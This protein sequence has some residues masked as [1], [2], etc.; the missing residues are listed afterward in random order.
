[1]RA[2]VLAGFAVAVVT[3]LGVTISQHLTTTSAETST[4]QMR[5]TVT[6]GGTCVGQTCTV[7]PGQPFTLT[8]VAD[9]ANADMHIGFQTQVN[10]NSLAANGGSYNPTAQANAEIVIATCGYPG[11]PI[12]NSP[13]P[14][15]VGHGATAGFPGGFT[16]CSSAGNLISLSMTCSAS[17]S[18]NEFFL[19]PYSA[20]NTTGSMW[21][22]PVDPFPNIV[23]K[24][25]NVTVN[26]GSPGSPTD[27]PTPC[28]APGPA[29][30]PTITPTPTTT[31]IPPTATQVPTAN[32]QMRLTV[33]AGGICNGQK[34]EVVTGADFTLTVVADSANVDMHLAFQTQVNYDEL[35]QSG[36]SYTPSAQA[37]TEV[38][39]ATC[40]YPGIAVRFNNTTMNVVSSGAT[41]GFPGN[42][43]PC[44]S[45]GNLVSLSMTCS[46]TPSTNDLL[47]VPYEDGTNTIGAVWKSAASGNPNITPAV[48]SVT[49]NCGPIGPATSTPPPADNDG[50]GC[51]DA[52][53]RGPNQ[54]VGGRR[55][56]ANFWDFFDTPDGRGTRNKTI[57]L[58][59]DT[60]RVAG[61]FGANDAIGSAPINRNTDPLSVSP[62]VP[63]Y[64]PAFDR[65]PPAV[66]TDPWDM[67]PP[68][69]I[70]DLLVDI[71]GV[72]DQFG[73]DCT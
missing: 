37:N 35:V 24:T 68:D 26:C 62:G 11:I 12:R 61:R 10:Y 65:S 36:G 14:N 33:T 27:T 28:G 2:V 58:L 54:E 50:D 56:D 31:P 13:S 45:A 52:Q 5:L 51:T 39:I 42:F 20:A 73:H 55:S 15:T 32:G 43:T 47:L 21:K 16:P 9:S 57:D 23:A 66:G 49:V 22:S 53:E 7:E 1:M 30:T 40:G 8:V 46:P 29:C 3:V 67:G 34:C 41:A 60:F 25:T 6:A 38:V 44:S 48:T 64:H 71:F 17:P 18:S 63:A 59:G 70:V 19:N 72:A 69:G 4:G